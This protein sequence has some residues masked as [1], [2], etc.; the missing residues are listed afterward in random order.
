[1]ETKSN[2]EIQLSVQIEKDG[3]NESDRLSIF[4]NPSSQRDIKVT[5]NR[6]HKL[7]EWVLD[8]D[9]Q[10][11]ELVKAGCGVRVPIPP[12]RST[13]TERVARET[14]TD[15]RML[16]LGVGE[17]VRPLLLTSPSLEGLYPFQRQGVHWLISRTG[18]ILADDMGLG[19]TVQAIAAMRL[20]FNRSQIRTCLVVCPKSLITTWEREFNSWSPELG[21]A[22][23]TPPAQ[24]RE[25][26]WKAV[27]GYRHVLLTNYEQLR[28]PPKILKFKPP[29]LVIADEAHRLRKRE[30]LATSGSI[31]LGAKQFWAL[32]GTPLERDIE[33]LATLLSI[34]APKHFSPSDAKLHPSSLLS[35]AH[36]FI[37]RRRKQDVLNDLPPVLDTTE[38]LELSESQKRTYTMA[39]KQHNQKSK[40]GNELALLTQLLSICDID[41][42]TRESCKVNRTIELIE[43]I[44]NQQEKVVVFS[45]RLEPLREL[46]RQI[47]DKWGPSTTELLTGELGGEEREVAVRNFQN[48]KQTFVLLAS[49]RIGAEGLTLIEANHVILFNQWWNPSSNDQ[50]R[51]RVVRIG[52]RRKVH[53][54]RFCC[55]ETIEE[56][57]KHILETKQELINNTVERTAQREESTWLQFLCKVGIDSLLSYK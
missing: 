30:T 19:K 52:Q 11:L 7:A 25:D 50:A 44:Y 10:Y 36:S 35:R 27:V 55:I 16:R 31:Q 18:G 41:P 9:S 23:I 56:A 47:L 13:T 39:I 12:K 8:L 6:L 4:I 15:Y 49:S 22:I 48:Y 20:L 42:N 57:L 46:K 38:M 21:V 5:D 24:I 45:Y 33:D 40:K 37:L 32:T 34:V 17:L 3:E 1:M 53:I 2:S 14:V 51:D 28:E 43:R 29:D 54:Y 26:A